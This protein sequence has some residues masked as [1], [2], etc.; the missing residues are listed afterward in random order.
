MPGNTQDLN[1]FYWLRMRSHP[2]SA[3][4]LSAN[5]QPSK[6]GASLGSGAVQRG[7]PVEP[8]HGLYRTPPE[9]AI[10]DERSSVSS[11]ITP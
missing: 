8:P 9:D 3:T 4:S 2:R 1:P 6:S 10:K 11:V 7:L 5:R